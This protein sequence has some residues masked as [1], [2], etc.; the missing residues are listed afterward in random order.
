MKLSF[1]PSTT[2]ERRCMCDGKPADSDGC[3]PVV[4]M[5]SAS[6]KKSHYAGMIWHEDWA[7]VMHPQISRVLNRPNI[8]TVIAYDADDKDFIYGFISADTTESVPVV[9]YVYVKEPYRKQG[10]ARRLFKA[11]GVDPTRRFVYTSK[12]GIVAELAHKIPSAR[13]NNNEA[14]YPKEARRKP[15]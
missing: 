4:A 14:R 1:R 2:A 11:I 10:I 5:W 13:F 3:S 8:R 9:Y 12:T 15:L 6:Y 7:A